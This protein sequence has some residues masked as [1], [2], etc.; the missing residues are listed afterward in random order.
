MKTEIVEGWPQGHEI[1]IL[2]SETNAS[3][4]NAIRRALIA[5]SPSSPSPAWTSPKASPKTTKA[6]SLNR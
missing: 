3:Q 4:V 1:R 5:M 2:I 6:K